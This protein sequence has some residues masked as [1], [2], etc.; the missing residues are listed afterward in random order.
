MKAEGKR[1]G[2]GSNRGQLVYGALKPR[3]SGAIKSGKNGTVDRKQ[4]GAK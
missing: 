4:L 2:G 1:R 3:T